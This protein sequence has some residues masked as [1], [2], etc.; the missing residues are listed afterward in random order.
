MGGARTRDRLICF[1]DLDNSGDFDIMYGAVGAMKDLITV[2]VIQRE[3][4]ELPNEIPYRKISQEEK[5]HIGYIWFQV[6]SP[7]MGNKMIDTYVGG[8]DDKEIVSSRLLPKIVS[9]GTNT[10]TMSG[11]IFEL[12]SSENGEH[13]F[14]LVK[15]I[16]L[17]EK[18]GL[19]KTVTTTYR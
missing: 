17:G 9:E 16:N 8:E 15:P 6:R 7:L 5:K 11:S 10:I 3:G 13:K 19:M 18:M 14:R 12:V 2:Y 4:T 1:R